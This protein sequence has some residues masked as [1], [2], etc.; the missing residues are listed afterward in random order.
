MVERMVE[1]KVES[2]VVL[3]AV[4][5]VVLEAVNLVGESVEKKDEQ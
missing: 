4:K 2:M 1:W 5:K 3:K